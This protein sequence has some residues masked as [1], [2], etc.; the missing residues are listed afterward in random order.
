M[1]CCTLLVHFD[2]LLK[3]VINKLVY[4][5]LQGDI[6]VLEPFSFHDRH[7]NNSQ[8][9]SL[10]GKV[11]LS[12]FVEENSYFRNETSN[13]CQTGSGEK[14]KSISCSKRQTFFIHVII[15]RTNSV[16]NKKTTI[17]IL[18]FSL[19]FVSVHYLL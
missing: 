13:K 15:F 5:P 1:L 16:L 12:L 18:P 7:I 14:K 3:M 9:F 2:Q 8:C 10:S 4:S 19:I 11:M 6:P 17:K